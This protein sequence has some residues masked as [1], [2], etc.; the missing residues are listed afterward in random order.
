MAGE[1]KAGRG[2]MIAISGF[3]GA[4]IEGFHGCVRLHILERREGKTK[5]KNISHGP[6]LNHEQLF[7]NI[8]LLC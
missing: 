3:L 7:S 5:Y 1:E 2:I 6:P 4:H 8:I